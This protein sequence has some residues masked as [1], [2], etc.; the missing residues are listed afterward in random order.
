MVAVF[1][2]LAQGLQLYAFCH[3]SFKHSCMT[4]SPVINELKIYQQ[5]HKL[6]YTKEINPG[7]I[8]LPLFCALHVIRQLSYH[9]SPSGIEFTPTLSFVTSSTD[10]TAT[11]DVIMCSALQSWYQAAFALD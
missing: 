4:F 3:R 10:K 2:D 7:I 11:S 5:W 8:F 6:S 9:Q 1:R